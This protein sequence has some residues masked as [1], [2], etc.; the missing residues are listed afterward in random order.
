MEFIFINPSQAILIS[1][2]QV[3]EMYK[4]TRPWNNLK[5]LK[6]FHYILKNL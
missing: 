4:D 6:Y 1:E 2:Y 5:V 3:Q